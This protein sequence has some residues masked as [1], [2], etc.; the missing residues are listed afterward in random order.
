MR[1]VCCRDQ[2]VSFRAGDGGVALHVRDD[3]VKLGTAERFDTAGIVDHLD[4]ELGRCNATHTDL[5]H[6]SSRRIKRADV[7]GFRGV[8]NDRRRTNRCSG[9]RTTVLI[10]NSLQFCLREVRRTDRFIVIPPWG[11]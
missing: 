11:N 5:R 1:R 7:Y 3:E 4:R 6:A 2:T 9:K 8:R 10:R